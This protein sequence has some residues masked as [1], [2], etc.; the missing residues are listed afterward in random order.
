MWQ[1]PFTIHAL[2]KRYNF[3]QASNNFPHYYRIFAQLSLSLYSKSISFHYIRFVNVTLQL[4]VSL[5]QP[6]FSYKFRTLHCIERSP[7][8]HINK[9]ETKIQK[10]TII[11]V[12]AQRKLEYKNAHTRIVYFSRFQLIH[13]HRNKMCNF[14]VTNRIVN[15]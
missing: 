10:P 2:H 15:E 14:S 3:I 6:P 8:P 12:K 1:A 7:H 9:I 13:K 5:W 4:T 11:L